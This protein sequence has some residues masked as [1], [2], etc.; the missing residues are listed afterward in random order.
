MSVSSTSSQRRTRTVSAASQRR[1][2]S[3]SSTS[4]SLLT[5]QFVVHNMDPFAMLGY[6]AGYAECYKVGGF[7]PGIDVMAEGMATYCC[8]LG[9]T[10]E[11][12]DI[13]RLARTLAMQQTA[14]GTCGSVSV[15][16]GFVGRVYPSLAGS[17]LL[18]IPPPEL[19][20][21]AKRDQVFLRT[22]VPVSG[23][24]RRAVSGKG[25]R[26]VSGKGR[27]AATLGGGGAPEGGAEG[28]VF[29]NVLRVI[30]QVP[31]MMEV[32][33]TK[34]NSHAFLGF[35]GACFDCAKHGGY[36]PMMGLLV[37]SA[38]K[39]CVYAPHKMTEAE[40]QGLR[41]VLMGTMRVMQSGGGPMRD[42]FDSFCPP[43]AAGRILAV[44][45]TVLTGGVY[46][47]V[48]VAA[49]AWTAFTELDKKLTMPS[50][51]PSIVHRPPR[52]SRPLPSPL[53]LSPPYINIYPPNNQYPT[54]TDHPI[55]NNKYPTINNYPVVA[56][57]GYVAPAPGQQQPGEYPRIPGQTGG[58][59]VARRGR[60]S[61]RS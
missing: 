51:R 28:G 1:T 53:P 35:M 7:C 30:Q 52:I 25:M 43:T 41:T 50:K 38:T 39:H 36:C 4:G 8:Q 44:V 34:L 56:P 23:K 26:A 9:K 20:E 54:I 27:R 18:G 5:P 19:E 15:I 31:G 22:L 6:A 55:P 46:L 10:I 61:G 16:T 57:A 29:D 60:K 59:T 17:L 48:G 12:A 3:A 47:V 11:G 58:K 2:R 33:Q 49:L 14:T 24:G 32:F 21:Q 13:V 37:D 42:V 40:T 45:A